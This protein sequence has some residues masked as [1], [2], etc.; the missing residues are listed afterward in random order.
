MCVYIY[1]YIYMSR[2]FWQNES[3]IIRVSVK[4]KFI[5]L[6]RHRRRILLT[7]E[8]PTSLLRMDSNWAL[9]LLFSCEG[10]GRAWSKV[11]KT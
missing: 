6:L 10:C 3:I 2:H 9:M 8:L 5:T 7:S 4:K 1:I 11:N